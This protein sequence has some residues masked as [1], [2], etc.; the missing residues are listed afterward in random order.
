M[1][2]KKVILLVGPTCVGKTGASIALAR[3][4]DTEII[5]ADSMQIYRRMDIGTEKPSPKQMKEIRHHMIDVVEPSESYSS[6][7]YIDAVRPIIDGLHKKGK[8]PVVTGGTG[9]YI[10]A[11]TRGL[12]RGP[13]A[14]WKLR[15]ELKEEDTGTLYERLRSLDPETA[16]ELEPNDRRRVIRAL[17]VCLKSG[18]TMSGL[19]ESTTFPLPYGFVKIGLSRD[20]GEL[21]RMIEE[22]VDGMLGRGLEGE[23]KKVLSMDPSKTPMQAIGYKEM[24]A[25]LRGD[26]ALDEAVRLIKRNTKRYAKRQFT[27]FKKEEGL[28]WADLTG[29]QDA[30]KALEKILPALRAGG[31]TLPDK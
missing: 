20:R 10:K 7:R 2:E 14:D 29:I 3:L 8:V 1:P 21:Y 28:R 22:R 18:K 31:I 6:G 4:I 9:L 23:V 15:G 11:M 30:D 24:A 17:E 12:F 25:Y 13:P 16:G 26:C 27:W 19:K 5:S